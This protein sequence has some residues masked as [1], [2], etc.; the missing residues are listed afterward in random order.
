MNKITNFFLNIRN[1]IRW[2]PTLWKD[3]DWDYS[4]M[5]EIEYKKLNNMIHWYEQNDYGHLESGPRTVRQMKLAVRLLDIILDNDEWWHIDYP[6]GYK[7]FDKEH[8]YNRL[9]DDCYAI[10][11]YV[12]INN[13]R[14]FLPWVKETTIKEHSNFWKTELRVE[15][16]WR[17]YNMLRERHMCEWWD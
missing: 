5:L 15:K 13:W 4:F 2:I 17:L 1:I 6:D 9:S 8:R 14:R 16:A 12:N 10:D 3:R 7:W 11:A